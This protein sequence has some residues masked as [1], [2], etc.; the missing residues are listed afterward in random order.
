MHRGSSGWCRSCRRR[1][2][3]VGNARR[4]AVMTPRSIVVASPAISGASAPAPS[5]TTNS[6]TRLA[7]PVDHFGDGDR[8]EVHA[9][10]GERAV[11]RSHLQRGDVLRAERD[12]GVRGISEVIPM[13]RAT[14]ETFSAPVLSSSLSSQMRRANTVFT[15]DRGRRVQ[16]DHPRPRPSLLETSQTG[17]AGS[18]QARTSRRSAM[19]ASLPRVRRRARRS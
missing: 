17:V 1:S 13:R 8:F 11:R 6:K 15:E 16:R 3:D 9:V 14:A 10:G 12:R 19:A 7:I 18:W 2:S 4:S 5:G